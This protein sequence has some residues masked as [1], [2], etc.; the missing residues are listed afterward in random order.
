M[1]L[2]KHE[3]LHIFLQG[4]LSSNDGIFSKTF[5][6]HVLHTKRL[7]KKNLYPLK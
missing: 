6:G 5:M 2:L 1:S 7:D 3:I 4:I